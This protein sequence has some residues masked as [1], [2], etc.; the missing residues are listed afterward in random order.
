MTTPSVA[1][2]PSIIESVAS[3]QYEGSPIQVH[4]G[5]LGWYERFGAESLA[6]ALRV[7]SR[8]GDTV[9]VGF[10]D[11]SELIRMAIA[12]SIHDDDGIASDIADDFVDSFGELLPAGSG[13]VEARFGDALQ[14]TLTDRGWTADDPW[15]PLY[16]DLTPPVPSSPLQ[17]EVVGPEL[18]E[19]RVMVEASAFPGSSLSFDRWHR[20]A[21]GH[22]YRDAKCLVGYDE[23]GAAVAAATVWAA[24]RDRPGV[25]EP[26]GVHA[27]HRGRGHGV[28]MALAAA[29]AMR[30]MGC[31]SATVATPSSNAA[32]VATYRAAGFATPGE[33][34]DFCRP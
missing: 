26:F 21:G 13:I 31:S 23:D 10:L 4:P 3:W 34:T 27:D 7:W 17:V 30:Q 33:V 16:R 22:A 5:D 12:P 28:A 18:I 32:A 19:D 24:G 1:Q 8:D 2:L 25:I 14:R 29:E 15:I 9:A 11:E 6:G 20:M